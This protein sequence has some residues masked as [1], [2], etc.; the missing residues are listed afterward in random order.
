MCFCLSIVC[1]SYV[2][3]L[4]FEQVAHEYPFGM[5]AKSDFLLGT[6]DYAQRY[7]DRILSNFNWVTLTK[8]IKW[9]LIEQVEVHIVPAFLPFFVLF[10]SS[11]FP[12]WSLLSYFILSF[13]RS[14]IFFSFVVSLFPRLF[15]PLLNPSSLLPPFMAISFFLPIRLVHSNVFFTCLFVPFS[16]P[17]NHL[18][19]LLEY[20]SFK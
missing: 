3:S 6:D 12:S 7:R 13:L 8:D 19:F 15:L 16:I 20:F 10:P 2:I 17:P 18:S 1:H 9:K 4:Q 11:F 14:F 5:L